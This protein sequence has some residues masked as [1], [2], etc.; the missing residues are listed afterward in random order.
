M[1]TRKS[2]SNGRAVLV[3]TEHR[4]VFF[5]YVEDQSKFPER[6]T[7]KNMRNCIQW[8][9]LHGFLELTTTGPTKSCK[10]GPAAERG[11][12]AKCTGLWDVSAEATKAWEGAPWSR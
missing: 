3:T 4:G 7:L 8:R 9:G 5:G 11:T 1:A 2:Q 10:I 6:I 12:L